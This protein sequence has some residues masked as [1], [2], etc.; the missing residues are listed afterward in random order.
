MSRRILHKYM[1]YG[2]V[3]NL[4]TVRHI[5][6]G[7]FWGVRVTVTPLIWL[8]PLLFLG[9]YLFLHWSD[10]ASDKFPFFSAAILSVVA[11]DLTTLIHAFGHILGG[12][13]VRS[14]MDEL[15]LTAT[16]GVNIYQGEQSRL[17]SSIHLGRA[18]GGPILNLLI[19]IP[20]YALLATLPR[21]GMYDLVLALASTNLFFGL[22]A[23]LPLPSVDGQV[24]WREIFRALGIALRREPV[25]PITPNLDTDP[26][27]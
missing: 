25:P 21:G 24:I 2:F 22:G 23:L 4:D 11:I 18:L 9:L 14:P 7:E 6:L 1:L 12:K 17:P 26:H 27:R 15:L 8:N 20:L 16:R 19:G 10:F 5:P 13:L 3:E